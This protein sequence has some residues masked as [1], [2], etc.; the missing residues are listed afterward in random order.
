MYVG[1]VRQYVGGGRT[2]QLLRSRDGGRSWQP[3]ASGLRG[4]S[5]SAIA[6]DPKTP[7]VLYA[8]TSVDAA[9]YNS[10]GVFRSADAGK[11]WRLASRGLASDPDIDE[12]VINP[13]QTST[14]YAVTFDGVFKT[15]TS[16]RRWRSVMN[17]LGSMVVR[18]L[19]IDPRAPSTLYAV[20]ENHDDDEDVGEVYKTT[21]A[22][23]SWHAITPRSD[24]AFGQ[25]AVHS[26]TGAVVVASHGGVYRSTNG[27]RTWTGPSGTLGDASI[28][29]LALHPRS[30]T[31]YVGTNFRGVFRSADSGQTWRA[32]NRGLVARSIY[33]LAVDPR[34]ALTVYAGV[35][36]DGVFKSTDGGG[37]WDNGF[38]AAGP[39][40]LVEA[41]AIDPK[42]PDKVYAGTW[43]GVF[44]TGNGGRSWQR[45]SAGM[46]RNYEAPRVLAL[47]IDPANTSTVYAGTEYRGLFKSLNGGKSWRKASKG[48]TAADVGKIAVDPRNPSTIWASGWNGRLYKSTNAAR[49]WKRIPVPF[50][51]ATSIVF[52]PRQPKTIYAGSWTEVFRSDDGGGTWQPTRWKPSA[53]LLVIDPSDP[54]RMYAV[55]Q[56]GV[57]RTTNGGRT[58]QPF[59]QGLTSRYLVALT[60]GP[61]GRLLYA[62]T[63]DSGVFGRRIGG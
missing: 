39:A 10:P 11:T 16:G 9:L 30:S 19:A 60:I 47:A 22:G 46:E 42:R 37:S 18:D 36:G 53:G 48:L 54:N 44:R 43:E 57:V 25:I 7:T 14:L 51:G 56:D 4:A 6:I 49:S 59:S 31:V 40:G 21:D 8:G 62:G 63:Y 13:L 33:T 29:V 50:K 35:D 34:S 15:T 32:T 38:P 27:G 26:S 1:I 24:T 28:W 52:D 23:E 20:A 3:S 2:P 58:W 61:G 45:S 12:L 5:V 55:A 17:G 41:L